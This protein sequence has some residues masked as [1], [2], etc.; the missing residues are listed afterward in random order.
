[1]DRVR[2]SPEAGAELLKRLGVHG[3]ESEIHSA[4]REF[5]GY[6]VALADIAVMDRC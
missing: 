1:M 5:R 6:A 4:V 2:F 3:G